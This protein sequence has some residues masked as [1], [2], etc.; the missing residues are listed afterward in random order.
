MRAMISGQVLGRD[1]RTALAIPVLLVLLTGVTRV[2]PAAAADDPAK[3]A[4]DVQRIR[5]DE[6]KIERL[7]R[8]VD[9][10]RARL[11][12]LEESHA[13]Q[14]AGTAVA[15]GEPSVTAP[16]GG[17]PPA[18]AT[19]EQDRKIGVLAREVE[20]IKSK[21]VLPEAKEYKS[22]YGFGPA[23]SKVYQVERG[24][25][26]G[27]YGEFNFQNLVSDQHGQP[28]R[29]DLL[30]FVLYTGYKFSDRLLFNSEIE[31]EHATTEETASSEGGSVNVEFLSLD[32]LFSTPLNFRAGLLLVPM[33]FINEI[34]EPPFFQG[35]FRPEVEQVLIP[36]T[37]SEGGIGIFGALIPGL[38][39][40]AYAMNSLNAKGFESGSI[41][42]ARQKGNDAIANDFAG[43]VRLD[44]TPFAGA[45]VGASFWA[46]DTG[47]N[48]TFDGR[49]PS[50]FTLIY[51]GHAQWRHRGLE[52][53]AL[54]VGLDIQDA[55]TVS[56]DLGQTIGDHQFGFYAEAAYDV[57]PLM[58][59]EST[60]YLA[61][62]FRYEIFD[63]QD[64]VPR[65]LARA[66]GNDVQLYTVGASYKPYPQVVFKLDYR[67]FDAG[68][69]QPRADDV[70]L[71]AGFIF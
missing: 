2:A 56:R 13:A 36:A 24:F 70:N 64:D 12:A 18:T 45:L 66:P 15:G 39:Y 44:Y 71:G 68:S 6:E 19:V 54:G 67:N 63:T 3:T 60:Q 1:V 16:A 30:R 29:F 22:A 17:P 20:R 35:V 4:T 50:V 69:R 7:Q 21:L 34:H 11:R 38:E 9:E 55:G 49:K 5:A 59:P 53:R 61:P 33:G 32:Y 23:A 62:F 25:S 58:F 47:Q 46:G 42:E 51:E 57:M 27:G 14:P 8:E 65:G 37:W 28:D 31:F 10:L 52:L 26:I 43:T 48:Q 40:R 41:R